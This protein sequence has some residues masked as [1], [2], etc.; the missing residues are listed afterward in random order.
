MIYKMKVFDLVGFQVEIDEVAIK[1]WYDKADEWNCECED[2]RYFVALAKEKE[3]P[4]AVLD[5]LC[6][7]RQYRT[8]LMRV[9]MKE[10]LSY[11]RLYERII[12]FFNVCSYLEYLLF[13]NAQGR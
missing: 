10:H 12:S 3:L 7:I 4:C 13:S 9:C 6:M 1:E 2:C 5:I 11:E 8:F